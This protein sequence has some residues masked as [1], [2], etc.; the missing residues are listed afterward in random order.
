MIRPLQEADLERWIYLRQVSY[1]DFTDPRDP[2]YRARLLSRL[3]YGYGFFE[4]GELA[5]AAFFYPLPMYLA[6]RVVPMVGLAGVLTAPEYRR[7]GHVKALLR[8][9]LEQ[10]HQQGIGW[11]L[12]YPFDPFYYAK[13]GWQSV[14]SGMLV[15]IPSQRLHEAFSIRT[16]PALQHVALGPNL[17]Q[18]TAIYHTWAR[19]YNGTL[20]R[21]GAVRDD[22]GNLIKAPWEARPRFL[23]LAEDAYC[24]LEPHLDRAAERQEAIVYDYAFTS[25]QGRLTLLAF[26]GNLSGQYER[27][28]VLLPSDEPLLRDLQ[29]VIQPNSQSF[30]ARIVDLRAALSS[31]AGAPEA[32]VTV[33]VHDD[34]CPWN[35]GR[36]V[37]SLSPQGVT[38]KATERSADVSL[39]IRT[40]AALLLGDVSAI[41]AAHAGLLQGNP[42][43]AE[44]LADLAGGQRPFMARPDF[45]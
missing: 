22:W 42:A 34:F 18:V 33:A 13:Y 38:V 2:G 28:R 16:R 11:C 4:G 45:F 15:S 23:Y 41:A 14:M 43:A 40:L 24:V 7:R 3:R 39:D 44:R 12:E 8:Y 10:L 1:Q 9:G 31:F 6:G 30:Q 36:F 29:G 35:H 5:S 32:E 26:W 37:V 27:V 17:D 20:S 25:P 21:D 19:R